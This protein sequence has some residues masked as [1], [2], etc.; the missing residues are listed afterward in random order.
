MKLITT[1]ILAAGTVILIAAACQLSL[2]GGYQTP[3]IRDSLKK[4]GISEQKIEFG[5]T[6]IWVTPQNLNML[7]GAKPT[8]KK[9]L[10]VVF[11]ASWSDPSRQT[12]P[13]LNKL[14][15]EISPNTELLSISSE[16][17]KLLGNFLAQGWAIFPVGTTDSDKVY[18]TYSIDNIPTALL[19]DQN[20]QLLWQ[21]HPKELDPSRIQTLLKN[22]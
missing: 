20:L 18:Q 14:Y 17:P 19:F 5:A 15:R 12:L 3:F 16:S 8:G 6:K 2:S 10:I 9:P 21:G 13:Y 11:W 4:I 1:Q 22:E 7:Q